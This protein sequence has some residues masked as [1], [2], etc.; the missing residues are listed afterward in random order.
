MDDSSSDSD[1]VK[2]I[3]YQHYSVMGEAISER[4]SQT[5]PKNN[6]ET[7]E[8][9]CSG[10]PKNHQMGYRHWHMIYKHILWPYLFAQKKEDDRYLQWAFAAKFIDAENYDVFELNLIKLQNIELLEAVLEAIKKRNHSTKFVSCL[11]DLWD[12]VDGLNCNLDGAIDMI[13]KAGEF[14]S[15]RVEV[16]SGTKRSRMA[17]I[18]IGC[19]QYAYFVKMLILGG[20]NIPNLVPNRVDQSF[21][22]SEDYKKRGNEEF[23]SE[24]YEAAVDWYSKAIDLRP[25]NQILYGN[26][27]L[28]F[29]RIENYKKALGDGK[30]AIVL[31]PNWPKGHYRLCDALFSMG[32]HK[33]AIDANV[34]AQELCKDVSDGIR[35]LIQQK[36]KFLK[37]QDEINDHGRPKTDR[38]KEELNTKNIDSAEVVS[39][40]NSDTS[41]VSTDSCKHERSRKTQTKKKLD[42]SPQPLV[43]ESKLPGSF[44]G[45]ETEKVDPA[46]RSIGNL[47]LNCQRGE[48]KAKDFTDGKTEG[49][50][51]E[52]SSLPT[53]PL[54]ES[55]KYE[56]KRSQERNGLKARL[57]QYPEK[58]LM[59]LNDSDN[60]MDKLKSL[61]HDGYVA[62][63]DQRARNAEH[64]FL[65]VLNLVDPEKQEEV[66]LSTIEYVL[67][68]YG[69]ACSLLGIGLPEELTEAENQFNKILEQ[70]PKQRF[71]SLAFYGLGK[72]YF[73]QN[74][75]A[76]ALDPFTKSL[77][78]VNRKIVPG[79]LTWP[80]TTVVIEETQNE[81]L[82]AM[83]E[84]YIGKCRFPVESDAICRYQHCQGH[85]KVQIYFSDPDFKGFIQ[86]MCYLQ[87]RVE[88]HINCWKKLK[89]TAF[90]DKNDKD[91]L[92]SPCFTPDCGGKISRIV[93]FNSKGL[94][95]CEFEAKIVKSKDPSK[96]VVK[97]KCSSALKLKI[98][99]DRKQTRKQLRREASRHNVEKQIKEKVEKNSRIE[100]TNF[101]T[102][103]SWNPLG[104]RMLQ[105]ITENK[106]QLKAGV[107]NVS[108]L[109]QELLSLHVLSEEDY[110]VL[111]TGA[112]KPCEVMGQLLDLIVQKNN[113]ITTRAFLYTLTKCQEV[114]NKL[115]DWI[116]WL[117]NAGRE[118]AELFLFRYSN[119][120]EQLDM[121]LLLELLDASEI[122][123]PLPDSA[124][125]IVE[126]L[127]QESPTKT[128]SFIWMLEEKRE[129]F[130]SLQNPLDEYFN[131]MDAPCTVLKRQENEEL[132]NI[133][134]KSKIR[135]RKKKPKDSKPFLLLSGMVGTGTREEEDEIFSD[136]GILARMNSTVPFMVPE[137]LRNQLEEFEDSYDAV[138]GNSHYQ[139]IL[140]NNPDPTRESLYDYFA[141][142]LKEHGP[143]EIDD[144]MLVGEFENFPPE[145]QELVRNAGGLKSFLMESLRFVVINNLIGLMKHAVQLKS[146]AVN[147][148]AATRG[149]EASETNSDEVSNESL[150]PV[151]HLNPTAKEFKPVAFHQS[152]LSCP[153]STS[154]LSEAQNLN[155]HLHY[156][157]EPG[158]NISTDNVYMNINPYSDVRPEIHRSDISL[159]DHN[160][161]TSGPM[162][163]HYLSAVASTSQPSSVC[164]PTFCSG[165]SSNP[166]HADGAQVIPV[167]SIHQSNLP[168]TN[169]NYQFH[170]LNPDGGCNPMTNEMENMRLPSTNAN[171]TVIG[172]LEETLHSNFKPGGSNGASKKMSNKEPDNTSNKKC[173]NK[174]GPLLRTIAV[175]VHRESLCNT[176]INTDPFQPFEN[177]QGDI[178]RIEKEHNVLQQQL[179]EAE[180]KYDQ[181]AIRSI[182]EITA[183]E[184][185]MSEFIQ[186]NEL[187]KSELDLL[188]QDLESEIKK[189]QQEKR[190]NHET[191][192]IL[193][194]KVKSLVELNQMHTQNIQEKEQLYKKC[195]Q[196][197]EEISNQSSREK[198]KL[199]EAIKKSVDVYQ[200]TNKR[201]SEAEVSVLEGW[202]STQLLFH[203]NAAEDAKSHLDKMKAM[204][205]STPTSAIPQ[206]QISIAA[207]ESF[208]LKINQQIHQSEMHFNDQMTLVKTGTQLSSLASVPIP[209]LPSP[210]SSNIMLEKSPIDDPAIIAS[211]SS[212]TSQ[213]LG[214]HMQNQNSSIPQASSITTQKTMSSLVQVAPGTAEAKT[215]APTQASVTSSFQNQSSLNQIQREASLTK[216][217]SAWS[218]KNNRS[219]TPTLPEHAISTDTLPSIRQH[220]NAKSQQ[221][222]NSFEKII[223]RLLAMFPHYTRFSLTNFIKDVRSANGGSLSGLVYDEIIS[224]VADLIL[225]HQDETRVQISSVSLQQ[226]ATLVHQRP[227]S[228]FAA[229]LLAVS[230]ATSEG[231]RPS[232]PP[233]A[234]NIKARDAFS[235]PWRTVSVQTASQW[236]GNDPA[237]FDDEPCIICHEDLTPDTMCVLECKHHFHELCI[238]QWL[239]ENSTCP[240]CRVHA[241]LPEDF[242]VLPG[243]IK[244]TPTF[245]FL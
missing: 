76:D 65:Q 158:L 207:W 225:D 23:K 196:E 186:K 189:S 14:N 163:D 175:Q 54:C 238:K 28:C 121:G 180:E 22:E 24:N 86:V 92:R 58:M 150:R 43:R 123:L 46:N 237:T 144:S 104:D 188:R 194:S 229:T 107:Q 116:N 156:D 81:K 199:E 183:L 13:E 126:Q 227:S 205:A 15:V 19:F 45:L 79:I 181:L 203:Y 96:T 162:T 145:A 12:K 88:Y 117:N 35:D 113:R 95:K 60:L 3:G 135:N 171:T 154:S 231:S 157:T 228:D 168:I 213:L 118:A 182:N 236:H 226:P 142:I 214:L 230:A 127:K 5:K 97:Q 62:L 67:I 193:K 220:V 245:P 174:R 20:G 68:I 52:Q 109:L 139:W 219:A 195:F 55:H 106:E 11:L 197:F 177:Q 147:E 187:L 234:R 29:L 64:A 105:L 18:A 146:L 85:S 33:Q 129:Q 91:F 1:D 80:T 222:K 167:F 38:L 87:C 21:Q 159:L 200:E 10:I 17:A 140:D 77:T 47:V 243:M 36:A 63:L 190:Q 185:K 53:Q 160:L 201:A 235:Q 134:L 164:D 25:D 30:R 244:N 172:V 184:E 132:S 98:K 130:P 101:K 161:K 34:K 170:S 84:E 149:T 210:P 44:V 221:S 166:M 56:S 41:N 108:N 49:R 122:D 153:S 99:E 8:V 114:D 178:L 155:Q 152:S 212:P 102:G 218:P 133:G 39:E 40:L 125:E 112:S 50:S 239:R 100:E 110:D 206:L 224:R 31:K 42:K 217:Q 242:P 216:R 128:R 6:M 137:Y 211:F 94:V 115:L 124:K 83:L 241:L 57:P 61:I 93:I 51:G 176:K 16:N 89:A 74:R 69:H 179:Q 240:T 232:T 131:T 204:A 78:M 27:A 2:L 73:R 111:S 198:K 32:E 120:I 138:P 82:K 7:A 119:C 136:D 202:Q 59:P 173:E 223:N 26:R 215:K 148:K 209:S 48:T 191:L 9:W 208:L 90:E 70:F 37:L 103:Q 233:A 71:D 141:Q 169:Y 4:S 66:P 143:M 72:V 75:F 165:L 151:A 192:K